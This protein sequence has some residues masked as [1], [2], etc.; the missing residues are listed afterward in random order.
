MLTF[1]KRR[2]HVT[3]Q[4]ARENTRVRRAGGQLA[5]NFYGGFH[6]KEQ[7]RQGKQG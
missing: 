6:R 3:P 1:P 4:G 2:G 5:K 7:A